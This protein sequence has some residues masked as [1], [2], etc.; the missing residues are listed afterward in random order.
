MPALPLLGVIFRR[1]IGMLILI[2][3]MTI[4]MPFILLIPDIRA[5]SSEFLAMMEYCSP[6]PN[7]GRLIF[8]S[9]SAFALYAFASASSMESIGLERMMLSRTALSSMENSFCASESEVCTG[10]S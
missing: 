9:I 1:K 3:G 10:R 6:M 2:I 4:S 7:M 5:I 8:L